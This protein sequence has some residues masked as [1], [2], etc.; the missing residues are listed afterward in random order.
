[1]VAGNDRVVGRIAQLPQPCSR[2]ANF[3]AAGEVYEVAGD[4]EMI[5]L[6]GANIV[7][8]KIERAAEKVLAPIAMP[9]PQS[10]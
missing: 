10:Q 4:G 3:N 5:D 9:V 8:E 2:G 7:Q 6:P 1:M